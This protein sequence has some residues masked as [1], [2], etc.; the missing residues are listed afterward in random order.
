MNPRYWPIFNRAPTAQENLRDCWFLPRAGDSAKGRAITPIA[1][2][3]STRAHPSH[4]R[5]APCSL[6]LR[7]RDK[8]HR[9]DWPEGIDTGKG[10]KDL[11]V[12][13]HGLLSAIPHAGR[14]PGAAARVIQAI[15]VRDRTKTAASVSTRVRASLRSCEGSTRR[16]PA[17]DLADTV[18]TR[19]ATDGPTL[20]FSGISDLQSHD[21]RSRKKGFRPRSLMTFNTLGRKDGRSPSM[22]LA[23]LPNF[24]SVQA[25]GPSNPDRG[26]GGGK[27]GAVAM[28]DLPS[29]FRAASSRTSCCIPQQIAAPS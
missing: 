5:Y 16:S 22:P 26:V 6:C 18:Q 29:R 15:A 7:R 21:R 19:L 13:E 1:N 4:A 2:R 9:S 24:C 11:I 12:R 8:A 14:Q 23:K 28:I 20:A 17:T 3:A 10:A 25:S 27:T